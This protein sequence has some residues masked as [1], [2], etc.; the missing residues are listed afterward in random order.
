MA[1]IAFELALPGRIVFGAGVAAQ[2]ASALASLAAQRVLLVVGSSPE[3]SLGL[4]QGWPVRAVHVIPAEPTLAMVEEGRALARR[5]RCDVVIA[6]GGGSAID[7]GKAIAALAG[8]EGEI[9]DYLEV[10]GRAQALP[11][12]GLPCLA[13]PTTAG[14]GAEVTR[15]SV[16]LVPQAKVKA[17]LRSPH[18]LPAL[19]LVDPDLLAGV[20]PA[21]TA[22]CAAHRGS[23]R[24]APQLS[25]PVRREVQHGLAWAV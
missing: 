18:L 4:R 8:N 23:D 12:P 21:V 9:L 25:A 11:R 7:A 20:P 17:S 1:G 10:V 24:L 6:C 14:T 19:A 3:R 22:V 15:N 13:I 16:L 2:A 5:E